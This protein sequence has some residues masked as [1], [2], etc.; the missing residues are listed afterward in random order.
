MFDI[1]FQEILIILAIA[2]IFIGP[3]RLP[4]VASTL[5]KGFGEFKKTLDAFKE[6]AAVD[7]RTDLEKA[8]L[9]S[10]HPEM[11][12]KDAEAAAVRA[13]AEETAAREKQTADAYAQA[14]PPAPAGEAPA[15]GSSPEEEPPVHEAET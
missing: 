7:I 3:K 15:A 14:N 13:E 11:A 6:S 8:D 4:E 12:E 9:L 1:G 2:L 5:G 10:K